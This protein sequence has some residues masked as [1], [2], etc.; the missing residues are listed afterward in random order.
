MQMSPPRKTLLKI[1]SHFSECN[2]LFVFFCLLIKFIFTSCKISVYFPFTLRGEVTLIFMVNYQE[3]QI[4]LWRKKK[5]KETKWFDES[6]TSIH[7]RCHHWFMLIKMVSCNVQC[8]NITGK[9]NIILHYHTETGD[10][11]Q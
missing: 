3:Y 6:W 2:T 1:L 5:D 7:T 8:G 4:L 11:V 10:I 9:V